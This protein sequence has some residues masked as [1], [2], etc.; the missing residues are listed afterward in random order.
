MLK[1]KLKLPV[2]EK[3]RRAF[4]DRLGS[5]VAG[6]DDKEDECGGS[7]VVFEPGEELE[8]FHPNGFGSDRKSDGKDDKFH[9]ESDV[10][11]RPRPDRDG[12]GP[13]LALRVIAAD[14]KDPILI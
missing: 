3:A 5:L 9:E 14:E 2:P 12:A 11:V 8:T 6:L 13:A 10:K 7:D 1:G 4:P